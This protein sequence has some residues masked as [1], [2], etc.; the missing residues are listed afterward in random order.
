M[1][2]NMKM[3]TIAIQVIIILMSSTA[4]FGQGL[5]TVGE[6]FDG[7]PRDI[8][9]GN[10][11]LYLAQGRH[12][13]LLDPATG[14]RTGNYTSLPYSEQL[15]AVEFDNTSNKLFVATEKR[16]Y[17]YNQNNNT[18]KIWEAPTS[19]KIIDF[20]IIPTDSKIIAL[21]DDS[22]MIVD[23]SAS[24]TSVF[25]SFTL[26]TGIS[27]Y[28]KIHIANTRNGYMAYLSG[29]ITAHLAR[30]V[31]GL[32]IVNLNS[33]NGYLTPTVYPAF[34]NPVTHYSS[35]AASVLNVQVVENY[36]G[37]YTYAFVAC[38]TAGQ[39]TVLDVTNPAS[40]S[41]VMKK[42]LSIG[43]Q[44]FK[45]LLEDGNNRLFAASANILH[46][47]DMQNF[48]ILG[49][50]NTGFYD[51]GT[52]DMALISNNGSKYVWT[53]THEGVG[54]VINAVNVT[55]N[56]PVH[57]LQQ[58][59]ISSSDGGVAV[60]E[61]NSVYLPTF[62][63]LVRYD[64]SDLN[65]PVAV[66]ASYRPANGII[67]HIELFYPDTNNLNNA[68]LLTALGSG[69]IRVFPVSQANPNP[70][71]P[72]VFAQKPAQWGNDPV[73][74]NDIAYYRKGGVNYYLADLSNQ[75]NNENALQIY[76]TSTGNWINVIEQ[77]SSLTSLTKTVRVWGDYAFVTCTGGFFVV[78]LTNLPTSAGITDIVVN[79]WNND[80]I[81]D[82][83][84]SLVVSDDGNHI[85]IAHRPGVVQSYQFNSTSGT[86]SGPLDILSGNN[87][88]GA[89]SP[90]GSYYAA[91]SRAYFPG[92][93]GT[94]MEIDVSDPSNLSLISKWNNGGYFG[95]MQ[96]CNIYYFNN[97][98]HILS[99]KNNEG[100]AILKIDNTTSVKDVALQKNVSVFIQNYPN[101]FNSTTMIRWQSPISGQTAL[102][103]FNVLGRKVKTLVN[104]FK[105]QGEYTLHF[106]SGEL[107]SGTYFYQLKVGNHITTNKIM[108]TK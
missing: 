105:Q 68:L 40:I 56:Q 5:I 86:V 50:V 39:L 80:G 66:D 29:A 97:E 108:I 9:A 22:V 52:R 27:F 69:G 67:E 74:Q 72:Q 78:D 99:I 11:I 3:K 73:Y 107:P 36:G 8:A 7:T 47:I 13:A 21:F 1:K 63:G 82:G 61:W 64:I 102:V 65:N 37:Q 54:Y 48:N 75:A 59:W 87:I 18:H 84:A 76:N 70:G 85:Y 15:T 93:D 30:G 10:G 45:V 90:G 34:W 33:G 41:W 79:D 95:E 28:N 12:L 98:P 51:A 6:I 89:T 38:G 101:P 2:L 92:D 83:V 24:Q 103:L 77:H 42:D 46:S 4:I 55:G 91:L 20:K 16:I 31:Y 62:G 58:W 43:N 57:S 14:L 53:A 26:P 60:P 94:I 32:V 71:Q 104:E 19:A 17:I 81:P 35:F 106:N 49:S 88:S 96:D 100:F 23:Y 25:S 44:V